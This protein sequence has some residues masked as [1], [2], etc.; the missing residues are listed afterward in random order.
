M[1]LE[2]YVKLLPLGATILIGLGVLKTSIFF[3][4]FGVDIMSYLTTSEVLTLFLNDYRPVLTIL[5]IGYIH[6]DFSTRT[7]EFLEKNIIPFDIEAIF[8]K[9]KY[10]YLFLSFLIVLLLSFIL[11]YQIIRIYD[12]YVYFLV[13][14]ISNFLSLFF[15]NKDETKSYYSNEKLV[16][17]LQIV[18]IICIVPLLSLKDIRNVERNNIKKITLQLNNDSIFQSNHY[19]KFIGKAGENYF[20]YNSLKTETTIINTKEVKKVQLSN[21]FTKL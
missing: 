21:Y 17:F 15:I 19:L 12:L 20:F 2:K 3:N 9:Y 18:C 4:Y 14:S 6:F 5:I 13:L 16:N 10:F 8:R 1:D 11:Y 7:I